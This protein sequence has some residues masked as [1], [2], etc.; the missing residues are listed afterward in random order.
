MLTNSNS[1]CWT[2]HLLMLYG[3]PPSLPPLSPCL[4]PFLSPLL[5]PGSLF[6]VRSLARCCQGPCTHVTTAGQG[7]LRWH[8]A[9]CESVRFMCVVWRVCV[10]QSTLHQ[11]YKKKKEKERNGEKKG[12]SHLNDG[13]G[14][15]RR[16]EKLLNGSVIDSQ[17]RAT[18]HG[19]AQHISLCTMSLYF[20]TRRLSTKTHTEDCN[21]H[22]RQG[23][24][25]RF[26]RLNG[27]QTRHN[28]DRQLHKQTAHTR[29]HNNH[30][31][32]Q[33]R[34]LA[35]SVSRSTQSYSH[36]LTIH[37]RGVHCEYV[38]VFCAEHPHY[39]MPQR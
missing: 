14:D 3:S 38:Y 35:K 9:T 25:F 18:G 10:R 34:A 7:A 15:Q 1:H 21:E 33:R 2:H 30:T 27:P 39:R 20:F 16:G 26:L 4:Y 19:R 31:H 11:R 32:L 12:I 36:C 13:G 22:Y 29:I 17:A 23:L 5:S 37:V 8:T 28:A 6:F 24:P